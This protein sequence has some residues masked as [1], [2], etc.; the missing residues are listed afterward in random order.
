MMLRHDSK[1]PW[2]MAQLICWTNLIDLQCSSAHSPG[3]LYCQRVGEMWLKWSAPTVGLQLKTKHQQHG[4]LGIVLIAAAAARLHLVTNDLIKTNLKNGSQCMSH[5]IRLY[6]RDI[7]S[8]RWQRTGGNN[9]WHKMI[10]NTWR[11]VV[12]DYYIIQCCETLRNR[13]MWAS[14]HRGRLS[15][16]SKWSNF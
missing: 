15:K 3:Y 2:F 11:P 13:T 5:A 6:R 8:E 16:S 1:H 9:K 4:D 7:L 14:L 10:T 12:Y